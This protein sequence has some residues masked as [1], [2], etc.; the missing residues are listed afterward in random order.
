MPLKIR[1]LKKIERISHS[2][3][4]AVEDLHN[5]LSDA[6]VTATRCA[7]VTMTFFVKRVL[8]ALIATCQG[9]DHTTEAGGASAQPSNCTLP[10]FHAPLSIANP[11]PG[12]GYVSNDGHHFTCKNPA[13]LQPAFHV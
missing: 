12:P 4:S 3:T 5:A 7:Q 1:I 11:S 10:I 2:G 8:P 6:C 13:Q 9:P